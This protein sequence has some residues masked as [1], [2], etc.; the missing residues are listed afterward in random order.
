MA[1]LGSR[2]ATLWGEKWWEERLRGLVESYLDFLEYGV[3]SIRRG[4]RARGRLV[5]QAVVEGKHDLF[6]GLATDWQPG[7]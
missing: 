5:T 7:N 2:D 6:N 4:I 1:L 3:R